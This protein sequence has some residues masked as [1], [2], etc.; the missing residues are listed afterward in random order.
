MSLSETIP[1]CVLSCKNYLMNIDKKQNTIP[2]IIQ[3][4]QNVLTQN[5][6]ESD[7]TIN[8]LKEI[9]LILEG[10]NDPKIVVQRA[11][12]VLSA[13]TY[14]EENQLY[15]PS[16]ASEIFNDTSSK[17]ENM[18]F[19][20]EVTFFIQYMDV[21]KPIFISNLV[22]KRNFEIKAV[23]L[24]NIEGIRIK[25][26]NAGNKMLHSFNS[27]SSVGLGLEVSHHNSP[28]TTG[29]NVIAPPT[30]D[31]DNIFLRN[32]KEKDF[33]R[34]ED[35][36]FSEV[37]D[38]D[39]LILS[40]PASNPY[41]WVKKY[42]DTAV[43]QLTKEITDLKKAVL[44]EGNTATEY[45]SPRYPKI[46][47]SSNDS[48]RTSV[49]ERSKFHL[50][51]SRRASFTSSVSALK[52]IKQPSSAQIYSM[53]KNIT[54]NN[55]NAKL[56]TTIKKYSGIVGGLRK[57][58]AVC[59]Q[60]YKTCQQD[61]NQVLSDLITQT[62][63]VRKSLIEEDIGNRKLLVS[64]KKRI[65]E[66][67][68]QLVTKVQDLQDI[69]NEL[70]LDVTVRKCRPSSQE[71]EYLIKEIISTKDEIDEFSEF[72]EE[73]RPCW[74]SVWEFELQSIVKEQNFLKEQENL[75]EDFKDDIFSI[76]EVF[77]TLKTLIEL[78]LK[79]SKTSSEIKL[80]VLTDSD[81]FG[82]GVRNVLTEI[83]LSPYD[84]EKD[85]KKRL[86]ALERNLKIKRFEK[87]T[88]VNIFEL[89]LRF[90]TLLN[91]K[92]S[93]LNFMFLSSKF[94]NEKKLKQTGGIEE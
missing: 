65:E 45:S 70:K 41:D 61:I 30:L 7:S 92:K 14:Q 73:V 53:L 75:T 33:F 58:L 42:M 29:A 21:I 85:S 23:I 32:S 86:R 12:E 49:N 47:N 3:N 68:S 36:N 10:I 31:V 76:I 40:I 87:A 82:E 91:F 24:E 4:I 94:V 48:R 71:M 81:E 17:C 89:E 5:I 44:N 38:Q 59:K 77:E 26:G 6:D 56:Q 72:V 90:V 67:S 64:G 27:V 35:F 63:E 57:E 43:L 60:F 8:N 19:E 78:Q 25:N 28:L 62:A 52:G 39:I 16:I 93:I 34:I 83:Q 51:E 15:P 55:K 79:S 9:L 2:N 84:Y 11:I 80:E 46:V 37:N 20:R 50:S 88:R 54:P 74:K 69:I 22:K 1:H 13:V 18:D 66:Q